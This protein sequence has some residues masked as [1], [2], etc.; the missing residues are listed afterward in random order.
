VAFARRVEPHEG[1]DQRLQDLGLELGDDDLQ[2]GLLE[3]VKRAVLPH[4][5][6]VFLLQRRSK[7]GC[8]LHDPG[9]E[10]SLLGG[11]PLHLAHAKQAT[12][13]ILGQLRHVPPVCIIEAKH[14]TTHSRQDLRIR[15][16]KEGRVATQEDVHHGATGPHVR[17]LCV[18]PSKYLRRDEVW[19]TDLRLHR[20]ALLEGSGETEVDDLDHVGFDGTVAREHEVLDLQVSVDNLH[21]VQVIHPTEDL[22]HDNCRLAFGE[23]A[24]FQ[25]PVEELSALAVLH[26]DVHKLPILEVLIQLDDM[27]MV[28]HLQRGELVLEHH[29]LR[30]PSDLPKHLHCPLCARGEVGALYHTSEGALADLFLLHIVEIMDI[31][32]VVDDVDGEAVLLLLLVFK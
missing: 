17:R 9:V 19:R 15:V 6:E 1:V 20:L 7:N 23:V 16:P 27:R 4:V 32:G 21:G 24:R 14:P 31:A 18:L 26:D 12:D 13:E 5:L 29:E 10:Q 30:L 3:L 11:D 8:C 22:L 28:Q 2:T 25:Q